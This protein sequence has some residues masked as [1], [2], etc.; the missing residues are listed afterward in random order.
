MIE[1]WYL[2]TVNDHDKEEFIE[3]A[4]EMKELG[5]TFLA[6]EGTA[7]ALRRNDIDADNC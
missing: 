6:T 1:E 7:K 5:Y 4:K 3:I 2:A